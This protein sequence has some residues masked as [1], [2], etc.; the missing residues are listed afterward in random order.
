MA[1]LLAVMRW[2]IAEF[3]GMVIDFWGGA[4]LNECLNA[5]R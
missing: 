5:S 1:L 4:G 2:W 3:S